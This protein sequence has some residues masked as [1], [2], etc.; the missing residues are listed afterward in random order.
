LRNSPALFLLFLALVAVP[1]AAAVYLGT[2]GLRRERESLVGEERA[3]MERR[4]DEI[5]DL[6]V[7]RLQELYRL[8]VQRNWSEY[9]PRQVQAEFVQAGA[10]EGG[11]AGE[12]VTDR[13]QVDASGGLVYAGGEEAPA[14]IR[15][16]A[17]SPEILQAIRGGALNPLV[18]WRVN[19][20][21]AQRRG[22]EPVALGSGFLFHGDLAIRRVA[23]PDGSRLAQGMRVDPGRLARRYLDPV[24][25]SSV[26]PRFDERIDRVELLSDDDRNAAP[27]PSGLGLPQLLYRQV[28]PMGRDADPILFPRG[29]RIAVWTRAPASL[30]A[31]LDEA[32]SRLLWTLSAMA[33]VV[34]LGLLFVWRA[35]RAESRLMERKSEFVS[36]VSHELRTP[37]TSI[38]MYA[39]MLRE[40]WVK[41]D[42]QARDYFALISSES[43]RLARLVNNVL[44]FSRLE[45]GKKSF[46]MRV[47]DPAPVVREAA[48]AMRPYLR[49]QGFDLVVEAPPSLPTSSFDKDALT[50]VLVNLIDNAVKYGGAGDRKEVRIEAEARDGKVLLRVLDRGPGVPAEEREAIFEPFRRGANAGGAGG[51]GLGLALVRRYVDAHSGRVA[52]ADREGGG[53]AFTIEL[54]SLP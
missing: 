9:A 54:A 22:S 18:S 34:A 52:V 47:G 21:P 27:P 29:Y 53:A 48:E 14:D 15:E 38:R 5:R 10:A 32:D 16:A 4:A 45:R 37:L 6:F 19:A 39:D 40:G 46:E 13:F 26:V 35:V 8:E 12:P 28:A 20:E 51:S 42:A 17:R 2:A 1:V 30:L 50:Q 33:A 31:A 7:R 36:A 24:S 43:E 11:D 44:D 23:L 25:P 41:D 3:T 49:Q